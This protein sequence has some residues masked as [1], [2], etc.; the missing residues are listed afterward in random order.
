MIAELIERDRTQQV[1]KE[2]LEAAVT[3]L[4]TELAAATIQLRTELDATVNLLRTELD[5]AVTLLDQRISTLE[6]QRM[7]AFEQQIVALD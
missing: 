6:Q 5:K 7:P 1:T 2:D 4:R 3:L